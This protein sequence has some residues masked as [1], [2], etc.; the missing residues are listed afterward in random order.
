MVYAA[1]DIHKRIFQAAVL[2]ADSGELVQERL[3]ATREAPGGWATRSQDK[4]EAVAVEATTGWRWVARELQTRGVDVRLCDLGEARALGG[5]K[6]RPK[7]DRLDAVW[8]ARL[9]AKEMLAEAWLPPD[10]IQYLR[11]R[12]RL[13]H[14]L[15]RDRNRW[16]QTAA[17]TALGLTRFR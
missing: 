13:R 9:L 6:R 10:E 16:A 7:T 5:S 11:D 1:I 2:D 15:A 4:L 17:R 12:T 14:A 3:P 8:L